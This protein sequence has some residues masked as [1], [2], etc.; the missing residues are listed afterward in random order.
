MVLHALQNAWGGEIFV[1]KLKPH[2]ILDVAEAIGPNCI[3]QIVGIRPGEKIHE[4]MIA[5]AD[6]FNSYDL[7]K[8]YV[9]LP[10]KTA[11]D[12][13][14]YISTHDARK[15][16]ENF[17]YNSGENSDQKAVDSLRKLIKEHI[18][19]DFSAELLQASA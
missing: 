11:F 12:L 9:I 14:A 10:Q 3:K 18:D 17:Q 7:G 8:Y 4:E 5:R 15:V 19:P 16:P 2:R 6:A 1:L 13:N